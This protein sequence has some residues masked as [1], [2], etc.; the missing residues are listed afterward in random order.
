MM[1]GAPGSGRRRRGS[2]PVFLDGFRD[3]GIGGAGLAVA[4]DTPIGAA[5]FEVQG[6]PGI[7]SSFGV[8]ASFQAHAIDG[9]QRVT[10]AQRIAQAIAP[11]API[12]T[13]RTT[14]PVTVTPTAPG[15]PP[16]SKTVASVL[17]NPPPTVLS[18]PT[19]T[20][21]TVAPLVAAPEKT[22]TQA[23]TRTT[24]D[25]PALVVRTVTSGVVDPTS[26]PRA[27]IAAGAEQ[28]NPE[29]Q[30]I[31]Q[32]GAGGFAGNARNGLPV[33][34]GAPTRPFVQ[35]CGQF[36]VDAPQAKDHGG[37]VAFQ[38]DEAI[39]GTQTTFYQDGVAV[40]VTLRPCSFKAGTTV[41]RPNPNNPATTQRVFVPDKLEQPVSPPII[42][43]PPGSDVSDSAISSGAMVFLVLAVIVAAYFVSKHSGS[44]D[45]FVMNG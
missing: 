37:T 4:V 18:T 14:T 12:T 28:N 22:L 39:D 26:T 25:A 34:D 16:T 21:Q 9:F 31:G 27:G 2:V 35:A 3:S 43:G 5:G 40:R 10:P 29:G 1:M 32:L 24:V 42:L 45:T 38:N 36:P 11:R 30:P 7:S 19:L 15:K 44:H 17:R 41:L 6:S 8:Q 33:G 23:D 13:T 20:F